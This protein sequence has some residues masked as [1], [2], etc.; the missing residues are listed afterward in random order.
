MS[1][2]EPAR[3]RSPLVYFLDGVEWLGN[4]LPDPAVLFLSGVALVWVLS[5]VFA[6][7]E[8]T[9]TLPGKTD[10][11]QIVNLLSLDSLA[12]F[13]GGMTKTFL[14]FPPLGVVIVAMLGV[15]VAEHSGFI[16][17]VL[18]SMLRKTPRALLTPMVILVAILSHTAVDAGYVLVIPLA[19]II[20]YTAGRHPLAGIAAAFAGVSGGFSANFIPSSI[21]P[22]L[23]GLTQTGARI[24]DA[25]YVVNPLCNWFFTGTSSIVI[26]LLGW[27]VTAWIVEPKL[28]R[29]DV[30]GDPAAMPQMPALT[31]AD[32]RGMWAGLAVVVVFGILIATWALWPGSALQAKVPEGETWPLYQRLTSMKEGSKA[33]LMSAIVPLIFL[34]FVI[35]GVVHGFV[36]GTFKTHRDAIKGMSKAMESL[37]YYIALVFF[38]ALFISAFN[39]S[40]LGQLLAVKGANLLRSANASPAVTI[41]GIILLT[42]T[43]NL[44]IGSASAKW[45]L[46]GPIFV[47]ML[48][49]LGISP[50]LTQASYRVG[51]STTN[52]ITPL[53]PYFPLVV[54]YCQRYVKE[55]GIGTLTA[56]M[57]PYS[58]CFIIC[59][60]LFLF[61]WW[62]SG[63]ELG[64]QG[65]YVYPAVTA[66][67]VSAP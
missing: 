44:L 29:T 21:D 17:A 1:D 33:A 23:S 30:D 53:M 31:P 50:E 19:G 27:A 35:P 5:A 60:S 62:Q 16:N 6:N 46:L 32:V 42:A 54:V 14:D 20:F 15:G 47:P 52:I 3:R 61:I 37:A 25:D 57:L 28:R 58:F 43:V 48:M 64:I 11:I 51:D 13:L 9:E 66:N 49:A 41:G 34:F 45:G 12:G 59:W 38:C 65:G 56:I 10:P 18:K 67:S 22:L 4:K 2:T 7:F 40:Q 24:V 8:F 63:I 39:Q 55:T 36:S 26:V